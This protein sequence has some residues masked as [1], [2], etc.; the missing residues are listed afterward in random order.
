[1]EGRVSGAVLAAIRRDMGLGQEG[2]SD[3]LNVVPKT[4]QSWEQGR[5]PMI[6]LPYARLRQVLRA[7]LAGGARPNLVTALEIAWT[8]DDILSGLD[9][10]DPERHPLGLVVPDRATTEMLTWPLTGAVPR[11]LAGTS[12]ALP[13][14][15]GH[16]TEAVANLRVLAES[17]GDGEQGAMLRRQATFLVASHDAANGIEQGWAAE[18]IQRQA[19]SADLRSWSPEWA[20]AR[21]AAIRA[22]STG[23][24]EALN[25][26]VREGL[27]D[28]ETVQAN[29]RYWAYWVG[30]VSSLWVSDAEMIDPAT[31]SW[32]GELLLQSLLTGVVDAPYRE[33]CAHTLHSLVKAR[34]TLVTQP[35][36]M[37]AISD[38][39]DRAT[40]DNRLSSA[41]RRKL[42]QVHYLIG[43]ME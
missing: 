23:D 41:A 20:V 32:S 13:L 9:Q 38:T 2:L 10:L 37:S 3:L 36:Y 17:A 39:V 26:F 27:S 29:L 16:R 5:N 22:A 34:R 4:L 21:S 11:Q 40:S 8:A 24:P 6:R 30:E 43:S 33:L 1:M 25:K 28:P 7:L 35:R 15:A 31:D 19:N 42:E 12:A 18:Q 14:P